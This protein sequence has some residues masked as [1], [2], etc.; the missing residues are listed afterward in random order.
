MALLIVNLDK[1]IGNAKLW[2]DTFEEQLPDLEIRI[3]PDT[4]E[5]GGYR[6]SRIHASRFRC[7]AGIPEFES[8]VQ[9]LCRSGSIR[10]SS[11]AAESPAGQGGAGGGRSD[12]DR[13][14]RHAR[15]A[16]SP[17]H[18]RLS[19][20]SSQSGMAEEKDCPTRGTAHRV[21]RLRHDGESAG[22]GV[23]VAR[24]PGLGLGSVA[25]REGGGADLSRQRPARAVSE[26][27]RHRRLPVAAD[28]GNGRNILRPHLCDDAERG[29]AGECRARQAC[30]GTRI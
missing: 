21:S 14:R 19:G 1:L 23:E 28:Q 12:D 6:I 8:D 25:A 26:P 9:P 27:D 18:A 17:R 2:R 7:I 29:D 3:W 24:L 16:V 4:G 13:V 30:R 11:K 20:G 10:R 15:A 22:A 5:I